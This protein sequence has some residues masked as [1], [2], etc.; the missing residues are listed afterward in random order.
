MKSDLRVLRWALLCIALGAFLASLILPASKEGL[1]FILPYVPMVL[2]VLNSFTR[3]DNWSVV[4]LILP[5]VAFIASPGLAI[6]R[7]SGGRGAIWF[8]SALTLLSIW[9]LPP[10]SAAASAQAS[11]A[12]AGAW[13]ELSYGF[14]IYALAHTIAFIG[15]MLAP[16]GPVA[17]SRKHGFP[18]VIPDKKAEP[19]RSA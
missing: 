17:A 2:V 6:R 3:P 7:P 14:Y 18:V 15:C 4:F 11:R 5:L 19:P 9:I 10:A 12:S 13:S 1:P 16:P 8:V